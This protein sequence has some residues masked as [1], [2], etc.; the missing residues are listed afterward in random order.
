M[1]QSCIWKSLFS[2]LTF[3]FLASHL[4]AQTNASVTGVVRNE[5]AEPMPNVSVTVNREGGTFRQATQTASDGTFRLSL[6]STG[7]Y[8][9]LFSHVGFGEKSEMVDFNGQAV[10]L[11][12]TMDPGN[13]TVNEEV[14]VVGYGRAAKRDV[15]GAVKSL[16]SSE[17]NR[18]IINSP[19]E[20]LQGKISGVSVVSASGEPGAV[21]NITVR[22]PGGIRTGSTPLFVVDGVALDNATAGGA[23]NPLSFI[24]PQ[25]IE[26]ID[27][28]K[29]AS[30]TAIY[31]AR[32][33]NGVVLITTKRGKVGFS[34]MTY[35]FTGG[36]STLARA[37]PV[38]SADDYR[39]EVVKLGGTLQDFGASTDWQKEVT[40]N[41]F[42]QNHNLSLSGGANK[43]SY[44]GSF[45][46]QLQEGILKGND[47]KRYTGRLNLTQ[48]LLDDRLTI[49]ANLS[50]A[51]TVN[52]RPDIGGL[53][54]GAIS[55]N[56]TIP[57]RDANGNPF[58]F[59]NGINPLTLLELEKDITTINRILGSLSGSLTI[60]RGLVYKLNFGVDNSTADR[61]IQ[62]LPNQVP[63]RLG[64]LVNLTNQNRNYLVENYLTYS[65]TTGDHRYTLLGGHSYQKITLRGRGWSIN[66]FPISGI[67]PIYNPG[68]G[69]E[70]TL[71]NNRP[72]GYAV[73]NELQSFFSRLNY[74]F[75]DKYLFTATVRA[76]GSSKFG[77]NNKYGIFPSFSAA[78][79]LSRESFL[80]QSLFSNLKLRAGWGQTGNQEIPSKIT[81]PLFTSQVSG[82]TSYPLY[83][84]GAYPAGT[85]YTRL[86]NPDIQWEVS[87]QTN[88]G[89]D[90]EAFRGRLSGTVDLFRKVSNNILLEV[91]PA[92]PVQPAS[93]VW[94]NVKD[95]HIINKGVEFEL[96]WR[97]QLSRDLLWTIGGNATF[98]N[99]VVENS[100][101]SVIPSG[102]ASGSGLT[103]AT[104]NGYVNGQP[105]GTFFL[106]EFIGFDNNGLSQYRDVNKD[107]IVNDKD[108]VALGS[109]LP[110]KTYNFYTTL[111]YKR[112]D[113]AANFNGVS[114]NKIYDNTANASFYKL[115]LSKG[116]N[117]T[118]AAIAHPEE[119]V[120]NAAPVSSRFLKDGSYLRLNNLNIG[121]NFN[122]EALGISKWVQAMRLS[123]T[124]Q[125]LFVITDYDGYDPEVNTD[126][127]INGITSYGIDYLSYPKARTI[128]VG[129][130]ITF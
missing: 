84:T 55:N 75:K 125:N 16:K 86:A 29:D 71:A 50:A 81:Q 21:Q 12:I 54:G 128:L 2:F 111:S 63:L 85:S 53:I 13:G 100:P 8:R 39:R 109:A 36:R 93:T 64:R 65:G 74:Q 126:R 30:A 38:F 18:G 79:V 57:A 114:G 23:T 25:D 61:D 20:L 56:P 9:I 52:L 34:N 82:N 70:L 1:K 91:I 66:N 45:S 112:F 87:T 95:M 105:I 6:P 59:E 89:L 122:T 94:T 120:N 4:F 60:T 99:N 46:M 22:G 130:N 115:L 110:T 62:S 67:E 5:K 113:V 102:S 33:A 90:F 7:R 119:A 32:G 10:S 116:V 44:Y 17:F 127:T 41:A 118:P 77:E 121:Y 58:R 37:L 97:Q 28:L 68:I 49:D 73:I 72:T 35:T 26:S 48:K 129:F 123:L 108:R 78:W 104:I 103:S 42:T 96:A 88:I 101:Y 124:G 83:P 24:N 51:N 43:F 117:T 106:Q 69:Q 11:N 19:E 47:M 14:V 107:G 76:D 40:R 27:V 15:T 80:Q 31:G 98:I 92:D 3:M